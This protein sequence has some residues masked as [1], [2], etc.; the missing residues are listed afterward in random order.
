[1]EMHTQINTLQLHVCSTRLMDSKRLCDAY[2]LDYIQMK[3]EQE[4]ENEGECEWDREHTMEQEPVV[5]GRSAH[6]HTRVARI[7]FA[8]CKRRHIHYVHKQIVNSAAA[9]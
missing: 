2:V 7:A 4:G 5:V 1:M 6:T 8:T 9:S 3:G